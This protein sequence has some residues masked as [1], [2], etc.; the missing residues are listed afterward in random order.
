MKIIR[1]LGLDPGTEN[2]GLALVHFKGATADVKKVC[3]VKA[4]I[5]ELKDWKLLQL[6]AGAHRHEIQRH[7]RSAKPHHIVVERYIPRQRGLT[8][9]S[10]NYMIGHI[11]FRACK[12]DMQ[13]MLV[14]AASW[15]NKMNSIFDITAL[16]KL[17]GVKDHMCDAVLMALYCANKQGLHDIEQYRKVSVLKR[18]A[19][20]IR[21]AA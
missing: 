17:A 6:E 7:V 11:V 21:A 14:M 3:M 10:V 19:K 9:E 4:K 15:K 16:Y 12:T 8:N 18:L 1:I 5:K 2:F 13:V 20:A